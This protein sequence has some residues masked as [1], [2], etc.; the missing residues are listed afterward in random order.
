VSSGNDLHSA[1]KVETNLCES[2]EM[3]LSFI[4]SLNR[5]ESFVIG[6]G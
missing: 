3:C 1:K 4:R 5:Y 2:F 6:N